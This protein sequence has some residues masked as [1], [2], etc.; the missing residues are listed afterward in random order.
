M[1]QI[2]EDFMNMIKNK[3]EFALLF[4]EPK[5]KILLVLDLKTED[6]ICI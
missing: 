5:D 6:F 1:T 2:T 3:S 4:S